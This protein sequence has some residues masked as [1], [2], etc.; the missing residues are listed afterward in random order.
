VPLIQGY[1]AQAIAENTRRL[2]AE[3]YP[4]DQ[5]SAIARDVAKLAR[6]RARKDGRG[7]KSNPKRRLTRQVP[8]RAIEREYAKLMRQ[9]VEKA[10]AA[11]QPLLAALPSMLNMVQFE[12]A[13]SGEGKRIRELAEQARKTLLES[14]DP[15]ELERIAM[16]FAA[17]IAHHN[18]QQL[19]RQFRSARRVKNDALDDD[20][21]LFGGSLAADPFFADL[22]LTALVDGFA[23]ENVALIK[24]V[25]GQLIDDI[26]KA[27]TRA[28]ASGT[29]HPTLAKELAARFGFAQKRAK[30]IA[31]DQ[32]GKL[33]GQ[34]NHQRQ[35]AIGVEEFIWRTVGDERVRDEH[36]S[37]EGI[38]YRYSN[39]PGGEL[40]GQPVNC[41]CYA[42]PVVNL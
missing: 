22:G 42:E 25:P 24:S 1:S 29:P 33:Y 15:D 18:E 20:W 19:T 10:R 7:R 4:S 9:L 37:R 11:L 28:I 17:R 30:L 13:D 40:P 31:R 5:A 38:T 8:P 36:Q 39:P 2:I 21:L 35:T 16:L 41:R 27:T 23:A 3:G 6:Q 14:L 34:I 26:E 12:R 32:V